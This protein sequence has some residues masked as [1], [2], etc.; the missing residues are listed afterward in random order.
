MM[1]QEGVALPAS[2]SIT[3]P[4]DSM[5]PR[6]KRGATIFCSTQVEPEA[7]DGA[8]VRY[9]SGAV[10]FRQLRLSSAGWEAHAFNENY[11]DSEPV[12]GIEVLA[13]KVGI[14]ARGL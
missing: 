7:G 1:V 11:R 10:L 9:P 8:I 3:M 13:V 4:D 14:N 5:E 12:R 2:F 6:V